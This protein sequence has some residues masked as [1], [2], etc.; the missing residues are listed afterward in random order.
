M[1]RGTYSRHALAFLVFPEG[2]WMLRFACRT[3]GGCGKLPDLAVEAGLA[4]DGLELAP[5][6]KLPGAGSADPTSAGP[7]SP[8][9]KRRGWVAFQ[10]SDPKSEAHFLYV[11][12][13]ICDGDKMRFFRPEELD[14]AKKYRVSAVF[15]ETAPVA[16][17][18][19]GEEL[20][21]HGIAVEFAFAQQETWRGKLLLIEE[22]IGRI[23]R[24]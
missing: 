8:F 11:F 2:D 23:E 5:R 12:H 20:S 16:E 10:L 9:E 1:L 21:S 19:T 24:E 6:R 4:D 22:T 3:S 15:P 7:R 17:C 18:V 13:S 14:P